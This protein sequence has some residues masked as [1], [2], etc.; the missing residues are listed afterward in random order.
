MI[1]RYLKWTGIIW[2]SLMVIIAFCFW[3][4]PVLTLLTAGGLIVGLVCVMVLA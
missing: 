2:A 3:P 1:K 4:L